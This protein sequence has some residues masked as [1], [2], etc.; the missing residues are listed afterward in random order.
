[1]LAHETHLF[2]F[3]PAQSQCVAKDED[4]T[5]RH[6]TRRKHGRQEDAEGWVQHAG[7]DRDQRSIV[8]EGPEQV[9]PD[10]MDRG[11]RQGDGLGHTGE[12]TGHQY[13]IGRLDRHIS[14]SANR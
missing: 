12:R 2:R 14:A 3:P 10:V 9:L 7:R 6:G 11:A 1:M 4:R 5:E 8:G 13:N